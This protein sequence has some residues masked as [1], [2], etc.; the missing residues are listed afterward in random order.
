MPGMSAATAQ[1]ARMQPPW[2][3]VSRSDQNR[4]ATMT[5]GS[6]NWC[7]RSNE[8][9]ARRT[10]PTVVRRLLSPI[11]AHYQP[12]VEHAWE[13]FWHAQLRERAWSEAPSVGRRWD[14][15][16]EAYTRHLDWAVSVGRWRTRQTPLQAARTLRQREDAKAR[17]LA[18]EACDDPLKM[19]PYVLANKAIEG[20]VVSIDLEHREVAN[21]VR[22]R[23]PLLTLASPDPCPIPSDRSLWWTGNPVG[24]PWV[25]QS[26]AQRPD[27]RT[28][29]TLKLT[30]RSA[31]MPAVGE[32]ACFSIHHMEAQWSQRLPSEVP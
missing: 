26:V 24:Q 15:D 20:Q 9:R 6:K 31:P 3:S 8:A 13:L 7:R 1:A 27:G 5:A 14:E 12:L 2:L 19:I 28:M 10:D 16:R 32:Q 21:V 29:V 23:R 4:T 18:E 22:V 17:L 30:T 25:V 11:E